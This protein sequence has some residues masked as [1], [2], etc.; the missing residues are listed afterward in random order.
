MRMCEACQLG[1]FSA[2]EI[3]LTFTIVDVGLCMSGLS[4]YE[5]FVGVDYVYSSW[6]THGPARPHDPILNPWATINE[7]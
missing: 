3:R 5:S 4:Q 7:K 1:V 6:Y 2:T